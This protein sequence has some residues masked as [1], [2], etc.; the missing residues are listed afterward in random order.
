MARRG[1]STGAT[2][3]GFFCKYQNIMVVGGGDS[4]MEE[5]LYLARLGRKVEVV[6]RRDSLRGPFFGAVAL[7]AAVFGAVVISSVTGHRTSFGAAQAGGDQAAGGDRPLAP[8]RVTG[9]LLAATPLA[10]PPGVRRC[11]WR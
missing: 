3:D 4:A 1:V 6:H 2:C 5:A 8:D 7:H 11:G 10:M 9:C